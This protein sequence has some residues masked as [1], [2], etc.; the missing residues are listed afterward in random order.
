VDHVRGV[1]LMVGVQL[2][3]DGNSLVDQAREKG[4]LINVA[5]DTVIRFVPPFVIT[6]EEVD[7]VVDIVSG[8]TL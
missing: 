6:K 7:R 5:S 2:N 1:G 4:A 3:K 8:L